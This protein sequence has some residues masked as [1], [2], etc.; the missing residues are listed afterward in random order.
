MTQIQVKP[1][2]E[3]LPSKAI[4]RMLQ[5]TLAEKEATAAAAAPAL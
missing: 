2:T 3:E 4:L 1:I 5:A